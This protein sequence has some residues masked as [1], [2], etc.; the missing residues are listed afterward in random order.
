MS[1]NKPNP[2]IKIIIIMLGIAIAA[3]ALGYFI[4]SSDPRI[5]FGKMIPGSTEERAEA[6][7][8]LAALLDRV[9]KD[10][11]SFSARYELANTY[12]A[13]GEHDKAIKAYEKA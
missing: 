5:Y 12:M 3:I 10:K 13:L 6:K 7:A 4:S 9:D 2:A 8:R 1:N 11:S